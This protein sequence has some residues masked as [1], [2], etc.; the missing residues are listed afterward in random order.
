MFHVDI[1]LIATCFGCTLYHFYTF[2][3][4]NLLTRCHSAS[5]L[6]SAFFVSE[7][8]ERKYPRNRTKSITP[9]IKDRGDPGVRRAP[10]GHP[11]SPRHRRARPRWDPHRAMV[12][13]PHLGPDVPLSPVKSPSRETPNTIAHIPRKVLSRSSSSILDW[14]SSEALP[15]TLP[16]GRSSPEASTSPCMPPE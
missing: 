4:T 16:E 13:G 15:G 3:R 9:S 14:R 10:G 8:L 7:I 6:F 5:S 2:S 1:I 12:W 11:R